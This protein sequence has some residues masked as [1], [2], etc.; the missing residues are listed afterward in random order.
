MVMRD[1]KWAHDAPILG[2]LWGADN[3]KLGK[4][5]SGAL[6]EQLIWKGKQA[7]LKDKGGDQDQII[8]EKVIFYPMA[9]SVVAYDAYHCKKWEKFTEVRAYP[10][11]REGPYKDKMD[12]GGNRRNWTAERCP[13]ECRPDYGKD[14]IYC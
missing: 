1:Q 13:V 10:T 4:E 2:G 14:W 12:F 11:Q 6:R 3:L 5:K 9:K 7:M 8:L